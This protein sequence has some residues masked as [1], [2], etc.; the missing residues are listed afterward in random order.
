MNM[1]HEEAALL[2]WY[3]DAGVEEASDDEPRNY[4]AAAAPQPAEVSQPVFN[5][6]SPKPVPLQK[7]EGISIPK[8]AAASPLQ[9]SLAAYIAQARQMAGEAK[10]L[11][12]LRDAVRAFDGCSI[13][14]T[15]TNT[16]FGDGNPQSKLML[17]GE[18]PGADED[19]RGIPFCGV[20]GKLLDKMLAAIQYDRSNY[21]ITNTLFWRPPGNRSPNADELAMCRPFV[22]KHIALIDPEL[23]VLVGG[24]AAKSLLGTEQGITRLRGKNYTCRTPYKDKEYPVAVIYHPSYLLRQPATKRVTWQD[25]LAIKKQMAATGI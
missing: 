11:E 1:Q 24:V 19:I 15:A 4:F 8:Q 17:I 13:K 23:I 18:A 22:E 10:T 25:L 9:Q 6:V 20:S 3:V 2:Q 12:E 14:K 5:P 21:Y 7:A 16:V